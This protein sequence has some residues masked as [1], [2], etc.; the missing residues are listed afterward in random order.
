[1]TFVLTDAWRE[2]YRKHILAVQEEAG[3]VCS[4]LRPLPCTCGYSSDPCA[5]DESKGDRADGTHQDEGRHARG[6]GCTPPQGRAQVG[7]L[8][9]RTCGL[10]CVGAHVWAEVRASARAV[11]RR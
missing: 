7:R 8:C 2:R 4:A 3:K 1:M 9:E 5:A 11:G 10:R 6:N